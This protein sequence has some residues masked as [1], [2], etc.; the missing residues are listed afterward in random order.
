M[1]FSNIDFEY[2]TQTF[3]L[4]ARPSPLRA[5]A[6]VKRSSPWSCDESK[7]A[8][9]SGDLASFFVRARKLT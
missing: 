5:S 7:E 2:K 4:H 1:C 6:L 9:F 8:L 3:M